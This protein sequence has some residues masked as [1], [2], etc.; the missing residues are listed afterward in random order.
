MSELKRM[1]LEHWWNRDVLVD[2]I[3]GT[4]T[5]WYAANQ[6]IQE[7]QATIRQ[8]AAKIKELKQIGNVA[9]DK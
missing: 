2:D 8:Q 6:K 4:Y 1:T 5:H 7:L 3:N 9:L